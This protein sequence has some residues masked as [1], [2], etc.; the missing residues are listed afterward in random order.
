MRSSP[1]LARSLLVAGFLFGAGAAFAQTIRLGIERKADSPFPEASENVPAKCG[2]E[3]LLRESEGEL[4]TR[5][6]GFTVVLESSVP[7]DEAATNLLAERLRG[8]ANVEAVLFRLPRNAAESEDR[9]RDLV[10]ELKK[11]AALAK[12]VRTDI[13]VGLSLVPL[14]DAS[15][16]P[17]LLTP[18]PDASAASALLTPIPDASAAPALAQ[19]AASPPQDS[20]AASVLGKFLEDETLAASIDAVLFSPADSGAKELL[21]AHPGMELWLDDFICPPISPGNFSAQLPAALEKLRSSGAS[22]FYFTHPEAARSFAALCRLQGYFIP[23]ISPDSRT[24]PVTFQDGGRQQV[25]NFVDSQTLNRLVVLGT[26]PDS[27]SKQLRLELA[28][29]PYRE[30]QVENLLSGAKRSFP[31]QADSKSLNL[32]V[33]HGPLAVRLVPAEAPGKTKESV[34]VGGEHQLTAEEIIA[35]ERAW[36]AAQNDYVRSYTATRTLSLRVRIAQLNQTFDL[37]VVGPLFKERGKNFDW[38]WHEF[39]VNGIKWKGSELPRIPILQPEK[40]TT[41]PLKIELTEAYDYTLAGTDKLDGRSAYEVDFKPRPPLEDKPYFQGRAWIDTE[42]FALLKRRSVAV[43]LHGE[44]LSNVE[45]ELYTSVPGDPRAVLPLTTEGEELFSTAG[46][47]T[48]VERSAQMTDVR[49]N[50]SDYEGRLKEAYASKEQMVRDT[51][52]G[53]RYLVPEPGKPGDRSVEE[54]IPRKSLFGAAGLFYD[55]S[56]DYPIPLLGVQYFNFDMFG[57]GKQLSAFFAGALLAA[58]YTD[59]SLFDTRFNLGADLFALAFPLTSA[60][61]V[62]GEEVK[63]LDLKHWPLYFDVLAGYPLGPYFKIS[64]GLYASFDNYNRAS[65]TA[66]EFVIPRDT[67]TLQGETILTANFAGYNVSATY[68][69]A[70]RVNWPF[71]GIPGESEYNPSQRDYQLWSGKIAKTFYFENFRQLAV[72]VSFLDGANLDRFSRYGFGSF[73]SNTIHGYKT[74]ALTSQQAWLMNLSY[75]VNIGN[76]FRV[77]LFYDQAV[78]NDDVTGFHHQYF[79]GVGAGGL[80]NG[81]LK[82]S[83]IRFDVGVPAVSHGIHGVSINVVL[84]KLY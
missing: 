18:I 16:A 80:I 61:Y 27:A 75:G 22:R 48:A 72:A 34:T 1:L 37:T 60:Q 77:Q 29:G 82:N 31:L 81:P 74:G 53:L 59:P 13:R 35:R 64:A 9:L 5:F 56:V 83:L 40:V 26:R 8:N 66:G 19:P 15:A 3:I 36:E 2:A 11:E 51:A 67:E 23:T 43:N 6:K 4:V 50:P 24:F 7:L 76:V 25:P 54:A 21:E 55:G 68:S 62:N 69:T 84:L 42:T 30:A 46:R 79:S 73:N 14:C 44:T 28:F 47:I 10:F 63:R 78:L 38:A 32:D 45:T 20:A 52:K 12:G 49:I 58:N 71:W 41:L 57:K 17:T 70:H 65:D 33:S 39:Y